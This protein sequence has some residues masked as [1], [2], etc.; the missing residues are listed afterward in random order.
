MGT[1]KKW[2]GFGFTFVYWFICAYLHFNQSNFLRATKENLQGWRLYLKIFLSTGVPTTILRSISIICEA[3]LASFYVAIN[4]KNRSHGIHLR[5][6]HKGKLFPLLRRLLVSS[7]APDAMF[8]LG[9]GKGRQAESEP[10]K[11][12][13]SKCSRSLI[14]GEG[15]TQEASEHI[16]LGLK[17]KTSLIFWKEYC[18]REVSSGPAIQLSTTESTQER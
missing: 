11:G 10:R 4:V 8:V 13:F 17:L 16:F 7:S 12:F 1:A 5:S 3:L 6:R 15:W 18:S 9:R 14:I 2:A